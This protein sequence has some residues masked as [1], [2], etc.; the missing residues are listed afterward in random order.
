MVITEPL[1]PSLSAS[2]N[3][4][5]LV[6]SYYKE[7]KNPTTRGKNCLMKA[8]KYVFRESEDEML[9]R[10]VDEMGYFAA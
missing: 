2:Q 1:N 3:L 8:K 4:L 10:L 7:L 5:F 9:D 6:Q